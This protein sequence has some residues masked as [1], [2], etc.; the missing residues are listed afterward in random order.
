M[1]DVQK[2]NEVARRRERQ[3]EDGARRDAVERAAEFRRLA[4]PVRAAARVIGVDRAIVIWALLTGAW[5]FLR[6]VMVFGVVWLTAGTICYRFETRRVYSVS[7]DAVIGRAT[8]KTYRDAQGAPIVKAHDTVDETIREKL[9]SADYDT[10]RVFNHDMYL[11]WG[12]AIWWSIVTMTTVGYGDRYPETHA[13][14]FVAVILMLGSLVLVSSFTA[15]F[16]S[17]FVA[18]RIQEAQ[19]KRD[20]EWEEHTL[21]CGW[22]EMAPEIMRALNLGSR[23]NRRQV[24][25]IND[26]EEE[27]MELQ[28]R[29][30]DNLDVRFMRGNFVAEEE[31]TRANIRH[32]SSVIMLP[33]APEGGVPNDLRTIEATVTIKDL[34]PEVK[35]FAHVYDPERVTNVRRSLVDDVV[36]TNQHVPE[37][38]TGFVTQPGVPQAVHQLVSPTEQGV[39]IGVEDIPAAY[40][41]GPIQPLRAFLNDDRDM[42]LIGLVTEDE[43]FG[44]D[45]AMEGGDPYIVEFIKEQ[46]AE[47]RITTQSEGART[48][49]TMLPPNDQV[50]AASDRALV[51]RHRI[52]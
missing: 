20:V 34:A 35:V 3:R 40:V 16:A 8:T 29:G 50:I 18:R 31:L 49:V 45:S 48:R 30:Y 25:V 2:S 21:F 52:M 4:R 42:T 39:E 13:G 9:A 7:D 11:D 1:A 17:A 12:D 5:P 23:G 27:W 38:L 10:V 22:N 43:G 32:A 15:T 44:L 41:D 14:R 28:L 6:I 37:L 51:L 46:I 26:R 47:A 33:D 24:V 36:V 19:Q